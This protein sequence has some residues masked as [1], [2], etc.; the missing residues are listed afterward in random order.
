MRISKQQTRI[1]TNNLAFFFRYFSM[2]EH[3]STEN[4]KANRLT[5]NIYGFYC[6][7]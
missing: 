5:W 7:V 6:A 4:I 2:S 3:Q 1:G